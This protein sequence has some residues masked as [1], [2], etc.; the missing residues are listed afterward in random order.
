MKMAPLSKFQRQ[1]LQL[2][3]NNRGKSLT[4]ATVFKSAWKF[5]LVFFGVFGASTVLMWVDNNHLFASGLVGFMAA[6]VW[7]DLIYAR[8]NLHFLPV[9]DA[10]TDW[11]KVKALL[12]A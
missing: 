1:R 7:R 6:V 5:Y 3:L 8:M 12:D 9:S 4:L 10:V 2:A 11:D